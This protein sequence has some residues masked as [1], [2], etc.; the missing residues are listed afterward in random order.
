MAHKGTNDINDYVNDYEQAMQ[1]Y[2]NMGPLWAEMVFGDD[3]EAMQ[4]MYGGRGNNNDHN[5]HQ[6]DNDRDNRRGKRR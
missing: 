1:D 5:N 4:A 2:E 6:Q 3:F